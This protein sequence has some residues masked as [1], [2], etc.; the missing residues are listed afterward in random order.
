[1][2]KKDDIHDV[3]QNAV[4]KDGWIITDDPL[5]LLPKEDNLAIDLAA[6]KF[7]VATKQTEK[8]AI[9]VKSFGQASLLYA[10][11]GAVGQWINYVSAVM[12]AKLDMEVYIAMPL[13]AYIKLTQSR[14]VRR[15]ISRLQMKLLIID[16]KKQ[17]IVK[18]IN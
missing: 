16:I 14:V 10:F 13:F 3:T 4:E 11:H 6:E 1:M 12:E 15:T 2:P 18:W 5:V 8:I 9:E 7:F 17:E